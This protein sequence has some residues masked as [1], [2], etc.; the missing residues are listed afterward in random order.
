MTSFLRRPYRFLALF[1]LISLTALSC[2]DDETCASGACASGG[3]GPGGNGTGAGATGPGTGGAGG[4]DTAPATV[5]LVDRYGV[6]GAGYDVLIHD[7]SGTLVAHEKADADGE[8]FAAVPSGAS[9][10]VLYTDTYIQNGTAATRRV[11]RSVHL[12]GDAPQPLLLQ[13]EL[14]PSAVEPQGT[15]NL[16]VS[17]PANAGATKYRLL[18]TCFNDPLFLTTTSNTYQD[19]PICTA[20]GHYDLL[21]LALDDQNALVDYASVVDQTF[22]DG[23]TH[24]HDLEWNGAPLEEVTLIATNIPSGAVSAGFSSASGDLGGLD[25]WIDVYSSV[26]APDKQASATLPHASDFGTSHSNNISVLLESTPDGFRSAQIWKATPAFD[27]TPMSWNVARL[28]SIEVGS[29]ER[30]PLHTEWILS[31]SGEEGDLIRT[32]LS[33]GDDEEAGIW[34]S[35]RP[36]SATQATFPELPSELA[37]YEPGPGAISAYVTNED[38][39]GIS[40]FADLLAQGDLVD[41][42]ERVAAGAQLP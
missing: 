41:S 5:K 27:P 8:V 22:I 25:P 14:Y 10:Y 37:A 38:L 4:G 1:S 3:D 16:S 6:P 26:G 32:E 35:M 13:Y 24:T 31:P 29:I 20:D 30:S 23:T 7:A 15:I 36:T 21:V 19:V 34:I 39:G 2:T 17:F 42:G 28:A 12:E 40:S 18:S 33:W 11:V 9:V